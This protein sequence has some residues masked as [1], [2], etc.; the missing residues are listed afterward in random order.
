MPSRNT[1]A[2]ASLAPFHPATQ[3]WFLENLGPP[4]AAQMQAWP[5]IAAGEHTLLLAPTGSGKTLAAFLV[6]IDRLLFHPRPDDAPPG[7]RTLYISPL[8]ALAV[9]VERNLRVPLAGVQT[10][11]TRSGVAFHP[12]RIQVRSGDTPS[13]DRAR[14]T[15]QPPDILITTPESL[16]LLLTSKAREMLRTVETVIV[17]EIHSLVAT[18][19]GA[20][21]FLSLERLE[22]LRQQEQPGISPAQRIGLSAT[23]RPLKE[24]AALLGGA[25]AC[26]D[27]DR[28]PR[29][30][31]V[32]IVEAG[33][34][35]A[36]ELTI[37]VPVEDMAK[38]AG[39]GGSSVAGAQA[40]NISPPGSAVASIWLAIHPRLVELIRAHRATMIFVNSRR[41]AERLATAINDLAG[42]EIALAHHGSL[43]KEAR[44]EIEGRLKAGRLPAI[45]ATSSLELGIDMGA[46]DLVIQIES[47]PSI[48]AGMQRV[49]RSGHSVGEISRG[50]IFPKFRGDLL[51]C[52]AAAARMQA[53]QVEATYFPRNPLDV[54]AQQLAAMAALGPISVDELY[55]TAR[56]AA[57]FAD[58]PRGAFEGVLDLLSGRYP[59]NEFA[60]LKPRITWD[61]LSGI[62]TPRRGTQQIAVA[63]AGTIPDRGLYGVFLADGG[64][65][66]IS[67]RVGELDEEMV[68][69]TRPGD[70]FLLG[71]SSWRV[72][73]ITPEAVLVAP[74]PGEPGKMPF[75]RG[76]GPG[77]PLEFGQAI[78]ALARELLEVPPD[79]AMERL[80]QRHGLE[81]RAATNLLKYLAD[82]A[83]ATG[84]VPS[85]RT[86][87][88]ESF[89]D[90]VG[91]WRV[92]LMSPLGS[93]VHAPWALAVAAR[94]RS[95]LGGQVDMVWS[96]DGLVFRLPEAARPPRI[97]WLFPKSREVE[98]ILVR[99][100]G[101]TA[102]FATRFRENA[103]RALLLPRRRPGKRT[104]LWMQR[105]RA[106]DLLAVASRYEQFPILLETYRECL[107]DVFDLPGLKKTLQGVERQT[108][109]VVEVESAA[110]SP[111]AASLL[112]SYTGNFLYTG[113]APLAERRAQTLALDQAQLRE[114]LGDA[115]LR[116]LLDAAVIEETSR[117][118]A[119]LD[120]R[121][122]VRHSDALH[123]LLLSQGDFSRNEL[124][125]RVDA[126]TVSPETL[127]AWLHELC[128][129][130]RIART[131]IAGEARY[132]AAEDAG[133]YAAALGAE[134]PRGLPDVFLEPGT[135]P[136]DELVSRYA[137][138]HTPF[139]ED[140]VAARWGVEVSAVQAALGQLAAQGRVIEG[141]FLPAG[142]G[143]EWCDAGV[144]RLLKRRSLARL[145]KQVA[146]VAPATFA[147]FLAEWQGVSRPRRGLD[148]L[149]DAVE[150]LQGLP[151][152]ASVLEREILPARVAGY[153]PAD[154]DE[155]CASGEV[156]WRGFGAL[157]PHDGRVALYLTEHLPRLAREPVAIEAGDDLARDVLAWLQTR[158]AQFFD[159]I[160][161][162]LGG[163]RN[164]VLAALWRLVWAGHLTNDTL[165]P[166]RSLARQAQQERR[167]ARRR[168]S[169]FRS[170][171]S[172]RL[173]GSEGRWS[174]GG[175]AGVTAVSP[176]ERAAAIA[177]QLVE[178]YGVL[179]RELAASEALAGGFSAIYPV[180][181]A[182]EEAGRLR[183]G[184]F[185][186]EQ[187][188]AQ[189]AL[190]GA[191]DRLREL[192]QQPAREPGE[193]RVLAA[194][195]PAN[196]YGSAL[197]WPGDETRTG[198]PSVANV[199][200]QLREDNDPWDEVDSALPNDPAQELNLP[201]DTDQGVESV[202]PPRPQRAVG[203]KVILVDGALRGYL[204]RQGQHLRTFLP[205]P[206]PERS[207]IVEQLAMALA[208][209]ARQESETQRPLYLAQVDG[210]AASESPW[211]MVLAAAGFR[212]IG[213]GL[214]CG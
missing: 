212:R 101:G 36:L 206:Q 137:R 67:R 57:P 164:D 82:Q 202:S 86:L 179:T 182:M 32:A 124:W 129:A 92:M 13:A 113:D 81:A 26:A 149:L 66:R 23:Q 151:L 214:F 87:V 3:R 146:P 33:R 107:R 68:F 135:E 19:R 131:T 109:R 93:R 17:D 144:L 198:G 12:P 118:L 59:S 88:V 187:G 14:M 195:D 43:A 132:L 207:R 108:I 78:G 49:G 194:T 58:L 30:R 8:K 95:E 169:A 89:L 44:A 167:Q 56:S 27:A 73:E 45:V 213:A 153:R 39:G 65:G 128:E 176:T 136:L 71:A 70:V 24:V 121:R 208:E 134:L 200:D 180:L 21:L 186:A 115:E 85:D 37:E 94:L 197:P 163:F 38:L 64:D 2:A 120:G 168:G 155:L 150:L 189:F 40:A 53:G 159:D 31:P 201:D 16:Y 147:R 138:T 123:E 10:E 96:D 84:E 97:D 171:R 191:A 210:Q 142:Q 61:R 63:N 114:L 140:D 55:A 178:R 90:E 205:A 69:E 1:Q 42:E 11:A 204:G 5:R 127:D 181:K 130:K 122:P 52:S 6:A 145:R 54:L 106:A 139:T 75:W 104:P 177:G 79:D 174:L 112:F 185:V 72:V 190:P 133:R 83:A 60:E 156:V 22:R 7:I 41:L 77:R 98:Q 51:A 35:K 116:S 34:R 188:A 157:G 18:K 102:L 143:D 211:A 110:P 76:D 196:P 158:G 209:H 62:V 50:V 192:E 4:T 117:E 125:L 165:A 141:A 199:G 105:R 172:E 47:P 154:L 162:A 160:A 161:L 103:A 166:L 9:D 91:D 173:P 48:A 99:E 100:L 28:P 25:E 15:R 152:A 111:F 74:A 193:V 203:A 184:Y 170:R 46:V 80:R 29:P 20:H 183:R 119:R 148:G 126:E 175:R